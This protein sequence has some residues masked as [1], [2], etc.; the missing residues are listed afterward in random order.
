MKCNQSRPGFELVSPCPFPMTITITPR[1]SSFLYF[2]SDCGPVSWSC[3]ILRLHFCGV[4][5]PAPSECPGYNIKQSDGKASVMLLFWGMRSTPSLP[6]LPGRLWPG[7]IKSD[8]VQSV[9]IIELWPLN[10]LVW[11][12]GTSTFVGYTMPNPFYTYK[13]FYFKHFSLAYVHSLNA[14]TIQFSKSKQFNS[15]WPVYSSL[16]G[17]TTPD[18][19][20]P[21]CD[22]NEGVLHIP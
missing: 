13:Q 10:C 19:I 4:V 18:Q 2:L 20:R 15:I 11:F 7:V 6:L 22:G 14:K 5:R 8:R 12:Y 9:G 1:A 3:G 16:S 21:G 17:A